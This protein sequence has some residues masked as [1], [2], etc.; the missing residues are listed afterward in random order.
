MNAE[1]MTKLTE[2]AKSLRRVKS[3]IE[4]VRNAVEEEQEGLPERLHGGSIDDD[5]DSAFVSLQF[6][7]MS[8]ASALTSLAEVTGEDDLT[9]P[10][11]REPLPDNLP[12]SRRR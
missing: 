1:Q 10:A 7:A 9:Q 8:T 2:A 3:D 11:R 6:A 5:A 12:P 4:A